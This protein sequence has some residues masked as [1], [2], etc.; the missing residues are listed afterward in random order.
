MTDGMEQLTNAASLAT[1]QEYYTERWNEYAYACQLE[2]TRIA[3]VLQFMAKID[4][5]R[6]PR[7][8]DLG[9]VVL[10]RWVPCSPSGPLR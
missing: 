3:A 4:L 5:T 1:Q 2:V 7:I 10:A 6:V 9:T 8:C